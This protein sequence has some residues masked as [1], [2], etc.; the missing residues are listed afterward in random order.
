MIHNNFFNFTDSVVLYV[1][2]SSR[3]QSLP[4]NNNPEL[5]RSTELS[6]APAR[7]HIT[8]AIV[9]YPES[10]IFT[11]DSDSND[12]TILYGYE[13]QDAIIPPSLNDLYLSPNTFNI[14]ATM[15][16]VPLIEEEH[17]DREIPQSP[18]PSNII[19]FNATDD[20]KYCWLLVD[21]FWNGHFL[22]ARSTLRIFLLS[23]PYSQPPPRIR[24]AETQNKNRVVL[25]GKWW[26]VSACLRSLQ[27][28]VS[29]K[30]RPDSS[31]Y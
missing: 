20:N 6:G 10:L 17:T 30:G 24:N 15:A 21:I 9:A 13:R 27:A 19:D 28:S 1:E 14:L 7:D 2:Q 4:R 16:V 22:L 26:N 8:I 25:S 23:S 29:K 31:R 3:G 12:P 11:I 18:V 5:L